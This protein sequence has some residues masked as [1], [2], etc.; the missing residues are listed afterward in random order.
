MGG[1]G[2]VVVVD[3]VLE[4]TGFHITMSL[5]VLFVLGVFFLGR[6]VFGCIF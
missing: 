3:D 5:W 4:R 1:G 2:E 6:G